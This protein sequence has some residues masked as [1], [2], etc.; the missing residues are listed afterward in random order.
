MIRNL[1]VL[2]L[3][4]VAMVALGATMAS[5][6][7]AAEFHSNAANTVLKGV[8]TNDHVFDAAGSTIT[9]TE[10]EFN[11]TQ[12]GETAPDVTMTASYGG[13]SVSILGFKIGAN[14]EMNGCAYTFHANGE[15]G[16]VDK[17]GSA[18]GACAA[19]PITYQVSNFLG[20]CDVKVGPQENLNAVTYLGTTATERGGK[21]TVES[22][23]SNIVGTAS[24]NLCPEAG[25]FTNGRY[26]Q[27]SAVVEGNGGAAAIWVTH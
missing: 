22:N 7:I 25:P 14:V 1:K 16:V 13:C 27:G 26:T 23:V 9:C 10:A 19:A 12:V 21:I 24:G 2:G 4:L 5:G 15:V 11:G 20:E 8:S 6:A 18:E 17:P 3:S